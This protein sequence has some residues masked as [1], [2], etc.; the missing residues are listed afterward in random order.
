MQRL[1]QL[2]ESVQGLAQGQPLGRRKRQLMP[3]QP[4]LFLASGNGRY[5][6]V[7]WTCPTFYSDRTRLGTLN[8]WQEGRAATTEAGPTLHSG[9]QKKDR[10]HGRARAAIVGMSLSQKSELAMEP[11]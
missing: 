2:W 11:G 7:S 4:G 8:Q 3:Q 10:I 9:Q 6:N 5:A 1:P